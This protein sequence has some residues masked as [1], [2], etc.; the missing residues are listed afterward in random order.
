MA[1]LEIALEYAI[2]EVDS[3][4]YIL[5]DAPMLSDP[6]IAQARLLL[7]RVKWSYVQKRG[8]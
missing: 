2:N 6:K 3:L 5:Y 7:P 4:H 8:Y 1:L